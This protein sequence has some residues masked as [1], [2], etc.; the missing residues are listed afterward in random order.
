MF[1][2]HLHSLLWSW[3]AYSTKIVFSFSL[4]TKRVHFEHADAMP[5]RCK[6]H[7][8]LS[9]L[10]NILGMGAR[11]AKK[12]EKIQKIGESQR[13]KI[14]WLFQLPVGWALVQ[15][16]L[17]LLLTYVHI[18]SN[19]KG[20]MEFKLTSIF[21]PN[22]NMWKIERGW[23]LLNWTKLDHIWSNFPSLFW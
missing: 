5:C 22:G 13:K 8:K 14:T 15:Y 2:F 21:L 19:F 10:Q 16:I 17:S 11:K 4:R 6:G 12:G 23:K 20:V 9:L 3:S 18:S 1:P 7:M